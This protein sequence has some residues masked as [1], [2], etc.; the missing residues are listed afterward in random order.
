MG[1]PRGAACVVSI[2][3]AWLCAVLCATVCAFS[4]GGDSRAVLR[5][6]ATAPAGA[7]VFYLPPSAAPVF[8]GGREL[9]AGAAVELT[10]PTAA[11]SSDTIDVGVDV[12]SSAGAQHPVVGPVLIGC[13]GGAAAPVQ[14]RCSSEFSIDWFAR[15]ELWPLAWAN[16]SAG[17]GFLQASGLLP[18]GGRLL[19]RGVSNAARRTESKFCLG[20][21]AATASA[22][23]LAS[24]ATF[25]LG[26][27]CAICCRCGAQPEHEEDPREESRM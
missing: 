7:F 22:F 10:L 25:V 12:A 19:C 23:L 1:A 2:A 17:T 26:L 21:S 4:G 11:C 27:C 8:V 6:T 18:S 16:A 20:S 13:G 24:G 5:L 9:R 14:W 3:V 15:S